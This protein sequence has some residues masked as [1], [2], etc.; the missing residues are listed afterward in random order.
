MTRAEFETWLKKLPKAQQ[1]QATGFFNVVRRGADKVLYLV[2]YNKAYQTE[3]ERAAGMLGLAMLQTTNASLKEFLRLRAIA[4]IDNDYYASDVAWMKL[5][6]P[7]DVTIGPYE[8]YNDEL[9]GYKPPSKPTSPS[10]TKGNR[11]AQGFAD[12]LQEIENNLP[13]D[14]QY[15]NPKLGALAPIRVVNEVLASGDGAHGVRTAAFNLPNDERIVRQMGSKRVMLRNVQQAKFAKNL[16]PDRAPRALPPP[17]SATSAS[18]LLHSHPGPRNDPRHRPADERP[19]V[20]QGTPLG[21]RRSQGRRHRPVHA[22]VPVRSQT[23]AR[24]GTR[25]LHHLPRVVFRTL[26]FGF[27]KPR[28]GHGDAVQLHHR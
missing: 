15:R 13:E 16:E 7:I 28:Q 18:T 11:Q 12:H 21:H 17:I 14:A 25:A 2:P 3:L 6:A 22:A 19:P 20:A 9:F 8:T 5:D 27:T 1:E 26:R 4:F 24:G 23:A 10:A